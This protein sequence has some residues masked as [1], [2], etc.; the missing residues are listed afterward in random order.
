ME[1][2]DEAY[3]VII[4]FSL[5]TWKFYNVRYAEFRVRFEVAILAAYRWLTD[6]HSYEMLYSF[7]RWAAAILDSIIYILL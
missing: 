4:S 6:N 5:S 1:I 7:L 2:R 3:W